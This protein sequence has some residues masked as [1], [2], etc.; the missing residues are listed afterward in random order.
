MR[1][2]VP[3]SLLAERRQLGHDR[4]DELWEGELHLVPSPSFP[5]QQLASWLLV[6]W[7]PIARSAGRSKD[8]SA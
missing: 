3:E 5:H 8:R 1:A 6:T 7:W 2:V 4:F